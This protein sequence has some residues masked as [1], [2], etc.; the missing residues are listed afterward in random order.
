MHLQLIFNAVIVG[1]LF[2]VDLALVERIIFNVMDQS[3]LDLVQVHLWKTNTRKT[4]I[5]III[6]Y[7]IHYNTYLSYL[8]VSQCSNL[9]L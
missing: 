5:Y 3:S 4:T 6:H 2:I 9:S 7:N 8:L 1:V